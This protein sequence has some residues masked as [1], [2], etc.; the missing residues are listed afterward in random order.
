MNNYKTKTS[1][2]I[3]VLGICC[4]VLFSSC[5]DDFYDINKNKH[6]ASEDQLVYDNLAMGSLIT[7][8]QQQVFPSIT[9]QEN[10]DVNNYQHMYNLAGDIYSGHQGTS[11]GFESNFLNNTTYAML[12]L[13]CGTA[14]KV[15]YQNFMTP[16]YTLS[17]KK[18]LSPTGFAV[19]QILKVL[20]MHR[21]TDMYGPLPYEGFIPSVSID[22]TAQEK[23]YDSFF[24]ELDEAVA[25][26]DDFQKNNPG[27]KP[28]AAYDKY[29]KGDFSRWIAFAQSIKLRLAMRIV[30]VEPDKAKKYAEEAIRAG[31]FT[32]NEDNVLLEVDGSSTVNPLYMICYSYDDTRMGATMECY[33]KG[34]NDPR[35]NLWFNKSEIEGI[36]DFNGIRLGSIFQNQAYKVFS[37]LNVYANTPIQI[38]TAS[39]AYFLR[40]EAALRGWNAGGTAKELYEE[41]IRTAFSQKIGGMNTSAGD[42][43]NYINDN[44]S[45]PLSS[46]VDP[47]NPKYNYN[48]NNDLTIKWEDGANFEKNL[49][50]IITQK[51]IALY[52]DGQE[53]WSEFRRTGYPRII[54]IAT[55]N[56]GGKISTS[57]QIRRIPYPQDEYY[58]NING[59]NTGVKE[60]GGPDT[61]GTKLWWDKK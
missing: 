20:M 22:Y 11:N 57:I 7:Q 5:T 53:A 32:S 52:P 40:A 27:A 8:M 46:Y 2:L 43:T 55:N 37:K 19:G 31:V 61:G 42:A 35:I 24:V 38:M 30:Y 18:E 6:A 56:S 13:W 51:W 34:Y 29:F 39:E 60:L 33:L 47:L 23:I 45:K 9:K 48:G 25:V 17:Q 10:I 3:A 16:W 49:E 50:R 28:L 15:A 58:N 21:V 26:L 14:F 4:S 44:T 54:P 12:P 1:T 36:S 59:V 41:G